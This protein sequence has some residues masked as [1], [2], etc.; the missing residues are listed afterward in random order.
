[1]KKLYLISIVFFTFVCINNFLYSQNPN[2]KAFQKKGKWGYAEMWTEKIVVP[3]QFEFAEEFNNHSNIAIVGKSCDKK[4]NKCKQ[5]AFI[6]NSGE[7]LCD[8][9]FDSIK[10][11]DSPLLYEQQN[12]YSIARKEANGDCYVKTFKNGKCGLYNF[13]SGKE[14]LP[15]IAD[16]IAGTAE[17]NKYTPENSKFHLGFNNL[18]P[19]YVN[20]KAGLI[21]SA[22]KEILKPEYESIYHVANKLGAA[23]LKFCDYV[24]IIKNGKKG[25]VFN[26]G[27]I[28][29]PNYDDI[30]GYDRYKY[31]KLDKEAKYLH[32]WIISYNNGKYGLLDRK[33]NEL[34]A[35]ELDEP[36]PY[37]DK[38]AIKIIDGFYGV[39]DFYGNEIVPY[40]YDS[41]IAYYEKINNP[42]ACDF[43]AVKKNSKYGA[44]ASDGKEL[45]PAEY[46]TLFWGH[47][48]NMLFYK[49]SNRGYA[50]I[51]DSCIVNHSPDLTKYYKYL[52]EQ[53]HI[54]KAIEEYEQRA[55]TMSSRYSSSSSDSNNNT[56]ACSC[57][58]GS[59]KSK[60]DKK[61]VYETCYQCGGSGYFGYEYKSNY[62]GQDKSRWYGG[63]GYGKSTCTV[64]KGTKQSY[65]KSEALPCK[66]CNGSG[67]K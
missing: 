3:A 59:G 32:R 25:V 65:A 13:I 1:M 31:Y 41:I 26:D 54:K 60:N 16:S 15:P 35:C 56:N 33:G 10:F 9:I 37:P 39:T 6:K 34:I 8:F 22:G 48:F 61:A 2:L 53:A 17:I 40:K 66:C 23:H 36:L 49:I 42:C 63:P 14:I 5:Y 44:I 43:Y 38:Y 64:C 4:T 46:D 27:I 55:K 29:P 67:F 62:T 28:I 52:K 50:G 45:L 57:C 20:G 19:Y 12:E 24:F 58:A 30:F 21:N 7:L 51:Y 11:G 18:I 47:D